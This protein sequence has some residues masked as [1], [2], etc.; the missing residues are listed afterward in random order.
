[1]AKVLTQ[2]AI[3][4]LKPIPGKRRV[5]RDGAIT[6]LFIVIQPS[7]Y[8]SFMMRFRYGDGADK[9]SLGPFDTSGRRPTTEPHVGE[10][11]NLT[12]ARQLASKVNA[13]RAAGIDV[14]AAHRAR[15]HRQKVAI[16]EAHT[17]AFA[18]TV[19]DFII[20]HARAKTR[21]WREASSNLG[22]DADLELKPGGLAHRWRDRDIKTIDAHDLFAVIEEA[23]RIS[24]PGTRAKRDAPSEA[25]A[26]KL[27]CT[28]SV[29]FGWLQRHRRI[30]VNPMASLHLPALGVA[31]DRVLTTA[32]IKSFWDACEALTQPFGDVLRLLLLTGCRLNEIA[33][34]RWEEVSDDFATLTIPGNRTKNHRAL[35][36][37]LPPMAR[38]LIA[39]QDRNGPFV[40]STTGGIAPVSGWSRIKRHL[41][42][43]MGAPAWVIHDL[44]RT[45]ATGMAEIGIAPHIIEALLN[46]VSGHKAGVA[47]IYNRA[48]Y[49]P[50]KAAALEKWAY[51]LETIIRGKKIV[52][53]RGGRA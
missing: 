53:I 18:A 2:A 28:L 33:K 31:R 12:R 40:F 13:D 32:E 37:P 7:S 16:A 36:V 29:A 22:Y 51:H 26:R 11:L 48:Q 44:R 14:I 39:A 24:I 8:K 45:C 6:G 23:R 52:A 15:K 1:V 43:A 35:V 3:E 34:L 21:N 25:R 46:H 27:H 19:K 47:G 38:K 10:P 4:K 30:E 41:D 50:E 20:Q 42:A 9:M 5:I 49:A 17:N